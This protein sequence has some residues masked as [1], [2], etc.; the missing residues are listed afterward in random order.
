MSSIDS[1]LKVATDIPS[2][3]LREAEDT[4]PFS[5]SQQD[6]LA[7]RSGHLLK[8]GFEIDTGY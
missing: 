8:V 3:E 2:A 7:D 6:C 4:K 5:P 1:T